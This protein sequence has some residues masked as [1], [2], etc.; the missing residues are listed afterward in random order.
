MQ[1]P[2]RLIDEVFR[3]IGF[4]PNGARHWVRN[5]WFVEVPHW[6]ITDPTMV[7]QV[8]GH[9]LPMVLP[10]SVLVGRLVEYDQ[11]GH[12]GHGAQALLMLDVL[13]G[14]ID[15]VVLKRLASAERVEDVL[16]AFRELLG[17]TRG[18]MITDDLLRSVRDKILDRR[19]QL[20]QERR[21]GGGDAP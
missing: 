5:G 16:A 1:A 14:S 15:E 7:V 18:R 3:K 19:R 11:T 9:D 13:D 20:A 10:E 12:T 2:R 4:E 6:E 21:Q 17:A 8:G